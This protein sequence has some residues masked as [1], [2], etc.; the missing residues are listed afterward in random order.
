MQLCAHP[1]TDTTE[2]RQTISDANHLDMFAT[3]L[4]VVGS[5]SGVVYVLDG[6][7]RS[8]LQTEQLEPTLHTFPLAQVRHEF[9]QEHFAVYSRKDFADSTT[10]L[11]T[12]TPVAVETVTVT[13]TWVM[14]QEL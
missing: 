4:I 11:Y 8:A 12:E 10:R 2:F 1:S 5:A 7:I 3:W 14:S 13:E 6:V 9:R